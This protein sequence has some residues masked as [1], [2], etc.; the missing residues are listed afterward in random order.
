MTEHVWARYIAYRAETNFV[1]V[2]PRASGL[3]LILNMSYADLDDP[4]NLARDMTDVGHLGNGDV[5]VRLTE[6]EQLPYV[7]A[8]VRQSLQRQMADWDFTDSEAEDFESSLEAA[9]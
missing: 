3:R 9:D 7:M 4:R 6:K 5:L 8:L 2:V 1:D